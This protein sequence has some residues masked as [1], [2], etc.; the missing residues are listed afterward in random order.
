MCARTCSLACMYHTMPT[1]VDVEEC[2]TPQPQHMHN[3]KREKWLVPGSQQE[4]FKTSPASPVVPGVRLSGSGSKTWRTAVWYWQEQW[5]HGRSWCDPGAGVHS[6]KA[7]GKSGWSLELEHVSA[8]SQILTVQE[9]LIWGT[10]LAMQKFCTSTPR[11]QTYCKIEESLKLHA[12]WWPPYT[13]TLQR[14]KSGR[15]EGVGRGQPG[16]DGT[17]RQS[18]LNNSFLCSGGDG[19]RVS[20]PST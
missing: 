8:G 10:Q 12:E 7:K 4:K 2:N 3:R 19:R 15:E 11:I 14:H 6:V 20:E 13:G 18:G 17:W 1:Y 5:N 16:F 9:M